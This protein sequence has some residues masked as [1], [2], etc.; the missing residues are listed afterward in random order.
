MQR[1]RGCEILGTALALAL[2]LAAGLA[3]GGAAST[4]AHAPE[5]GPAHA[6]VLGE[7]TQDH[8]MARPAG[9]TH[10]TVGKFVAIAPTVEDADGGPACAAGEHAAPGAPAFCG[11]RSRSVRAP[12][13]I[14]VG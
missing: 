11:A 6:N 5:P 13:G 7:L 1:V 2:L 10:V 12:P 14:S 8:A 9:G 4:P 3:L